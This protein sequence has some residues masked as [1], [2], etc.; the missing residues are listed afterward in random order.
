[1]SR[2][3]FPLAA[4]MLVA[5]LAPAPARAQD[6][7]AV[8]NRVVSAWA[9]GDVGAITRLASREGVSLD[10]DGA[11]VG[12]VATRQASAVLRRVFDAVE[13]DAVQRGITRTAGGSPQRAFS[14]IAWTARVR[15][16]SIAQ[17]RTVFVAYVREEGGWRISQIRLMR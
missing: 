12:P 1:M 8:V 9:R 2:L 13:T 7:D 4:A 5:A 14:E 3:R 17:R 10:V 11:A 16:T 6:L 15:G